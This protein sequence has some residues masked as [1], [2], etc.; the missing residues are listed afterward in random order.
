MNMN[1]LTKTSLMSKVKVLVTQSYLTLCNRMDCSPSGTS[2][3]GIPQARILE[4]VAYTI[5]QIFSTAKTQQ[6]FQLVLQLQKC[7]EQTTWESLF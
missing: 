6:M 7:A 5:R 2:V 4:W 1:D 3:H